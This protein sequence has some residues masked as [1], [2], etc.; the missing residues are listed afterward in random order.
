MLSERLGASSGKKNRNDGVPVKMTPSLFP[1]KFGILEFCF[2][3]D[4]FVLELDL[5][6]CYR[7]PFR[8]G[9][10]PIL[11]CLYCRYNCGEKTLP[12]SSFEGCQDC[13]CAKHTRRFNG[14]KNHLLNFQTRC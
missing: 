10:T 6:S 4:L 2:L 5:S 1:L 7:S 3:L 12:T 8:R 14:L 11:Y 9:V 13:V